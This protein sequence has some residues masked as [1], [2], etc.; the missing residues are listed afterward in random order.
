MKFMAIIESD[1]KDMDAIIRSISVE[2]R[3]ETS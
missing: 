1:W 2:S 3:V